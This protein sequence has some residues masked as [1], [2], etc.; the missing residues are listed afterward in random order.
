VS[1][2]VEDKPKKIEDKPS[3]VEEK[4]PKLLIE[5]APVRQHKSQLM[6]RNPCS[7]ST[8]NGALRERMVAG[9]ALLVNWHNKAQVDQFLATFIALV[10]ASEIMDEELLMVLE[11][12]E[13]HM[14]EI[15][16][17]GE[18]ERLATLVD[19]VIIPGFESPSK[20]VRKQVVLTLA[21]L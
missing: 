20:D 9:Q 3:K 12:I 1:K 16:K 7:L 10:E 13:N 19:R 14:S 4:Q 6:A 17:V 11:A 2:K 21:E 18:T 5:S 8:G 15:Y